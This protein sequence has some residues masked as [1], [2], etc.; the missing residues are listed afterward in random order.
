MSEETL[1]KT[2]VYDAVSERFFDDD[3]WGK[4]SCEEIRKEIQKRLMKKIPQIQIDVKRENI[5]VKTQIKTYEY[6]FGE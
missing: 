6:S 1:I 3:L 4:K 2:V 5:K